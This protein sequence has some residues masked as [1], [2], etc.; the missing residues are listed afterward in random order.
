MK[1]VPLFT[2]TYDRPLEHR[3]SGPLAGGDAIGWVV[4]EGRVSGERL[5]GTLRRFTK[6]LHRADG[7]HEPETHGV[8]V[9]AEGLV[10]YDMRG[11]SPSPV[12]QAR[13]VFGG[14]TFRTDVPAYE[15]L[16][17]VYAVAETMYDGKAGGLEYRLYECRADET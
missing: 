16:N 10:F 13:Q 9:A 15:W 11:L 5:N 3:A 7:V 8:I 4:G 12:G 14:V 17:R 6:P 2:L 1:L